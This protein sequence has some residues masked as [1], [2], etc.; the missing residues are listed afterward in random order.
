MRLMMHESQPVPGGKSRAA[1]LAALAVPVALLL[2]GPAVRA[3]DEPPAEEIF[4]SNTAEVV[5]GAATLAGAGCQGGHG[6]A[7]VLGLLMRGDRLRLWKLEQSD[8]APELRAE[9]LKRVKDSTGVMIDDNAF[10]AEAYC[11]ALYKAT[12]ASPGAFANSARRDLTI[13]HLLSEPREYRGQVVHFEGT[14]R[15]IR[16][17]EPPAMLVAKGIRD[18][19]ECWL[20]NQPRYGAH[21]V[22]LVCSELPAGVSPGERLTIEASCDAYFFKRYRYESA[23]STPGHLRQAPLLLGR[24]LVLT[25]PAVAAEPDDGFV[26]QSKWVL[27]FFLGCVLAVFVLAFAGHWWYRRAD[28]RVQARVRAARAREPDEPGSP[29]LPGATPSAN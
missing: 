23:D 5:Q 7:M 12:L 8:R 4:R 21:P 13:A 11:E 22:C 10:E 26:A 28:R 17:L 27:V 20:F 6:S 25:R 15:L 3:D 9:L 29:G 19:Y 16:R 24:T 2:A 18:L 1:T 14:V